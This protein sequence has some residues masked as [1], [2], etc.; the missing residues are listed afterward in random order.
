VAYALNGLGDVLSQ[1]GGTD[2]ARAH[3]AT[4]LR[5]AS[6]AGWPLEQARAHDG[7]ARA[8]HADGDS[9]QARHHWQ[10]ALTR[11][12]ATGA[13]EAR[14]IRARLAM[15]GDGHNDDQKPAEEEHGGTTSPLSDDLSSRSDSAS[16]DST[17]SHS[18]LDVLEEQQPVTRLVGQPDLN[19]VQPEAGG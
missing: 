10:E 8:C 1:T 16:A 9:L 2:E 19:V 17:T 12:V 15:T 4:A 13:P 11:Y 6:E 5:L 14:D 3:H 18:E 7:L